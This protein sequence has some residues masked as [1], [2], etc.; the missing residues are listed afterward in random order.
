MLRT[1]EFLSLNESY[2]NICKNKGGS[3]QLLPGTS[4][5][6][7]VLGPR[8]LLRSLLLLL[9]SFGPPQLSK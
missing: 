2:N 1:G 7:P 6:G 5:G 9:S 3:C 4:S 8:R